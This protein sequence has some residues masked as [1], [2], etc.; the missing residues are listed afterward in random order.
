MAKARPRATAS[1]QAV[2][3]PVYQLKVTL[4]G[5]KPPI[6]RRLL[7]PGGATLADLHDILQAA[8]GW[9]NCHMHAFQIAGATYGTGG[10]YAL[11]DA[12][13]EVD[14]RLDRV[15]PP[16]KGKFRY[17]YDFGDDWRHTIVVEKVVDPDPAARYPTCVKG[18]RRCPPE[19]C[20]GIWGYDDLLEAL[21]HPRTAE[22]R[23][24]IAWAGGK[25]D[26]EAFDLDAVNARLRGLG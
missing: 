2:A 12:L 16:E 23:E 17:E 10:P 20:G 24:L 4:D 14:F 5:S 11:D 25:F 6:W 3:G 9:R 22:H 21:A 26:P 1:G 7:V 18:K 19:D 8:M 13:D 15:A